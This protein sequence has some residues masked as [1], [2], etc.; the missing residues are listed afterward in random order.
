[1]VM[2]DEGKGE[3]SVG[4]PVEMVGLIGVIPVE[5]KEAKGVIVE[6]MEVHR[7]PDEEGEGI[8]ELAVMRTTVDDIEMKKKHPQR[9]WGSLI[10]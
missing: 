1:M 10:V 4:E 9:M 6:K 2:E 8:V 7:Q 3:G 5:V